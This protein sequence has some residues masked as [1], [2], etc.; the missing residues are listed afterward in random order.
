MSCFLLVHYS[1]FYFHNKI[2][3][4]KSSNRN[5]FC[6]E[7]IFLEWSEQMY[8]CCNVNKVPITYAGR[9]QLHSVSRVFHACCRE[10]SYLSREATLLRSVRVAMLLALQTLDHAVVGLNSPDSAQDFMVPY[11]S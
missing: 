4:G 6:G 11:C 10:T 7:T 2:Y 3:K 5:N 8:I 1:L 9:L